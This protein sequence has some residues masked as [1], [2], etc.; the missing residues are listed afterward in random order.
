LNILFSPTT[1]TT[2]QWTWQVLTK[3][4]HQSKKPHAMQA[5][6]YIDETLRINFKPKFFGE[7]APFRAECWTGFQSR[8]WFHIQSPTHCSRCLCSHQ[9]VFFPGDRCKSEKANMFY[10]E[11][12]IIRSNCDLNPPSRFF[13]PAWPSKI[14]KFSQ[15]RCLFWAFLLDKSRVCFCL[16]QY[17][18]A[19]RLVVLS[20]LV[21]LQLYS[22]MDRH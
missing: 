8:A 7:V 3:G 18:M 21:F 9:Y 12:W 22:D 13:L 14:D 17:Q 20:A 1:L 19:M 16:L 10:L 15:P 2:I 11:A 6:K 5:T 4:W